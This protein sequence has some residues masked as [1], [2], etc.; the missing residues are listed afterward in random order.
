MNYGNEQHTYFQES[1]KNSL[2]LVSIL[3]QL[4]IEKR[5]SFRSLLYPFACIPSLVGTLSLWTGISSW[6]MMQIWYLTLIFVV[7]HMSLFLYGMHL[8]G[9]YNLISIFLWEKISQ[10]YFYKFNSLFPNKFSLHKSSKRRIIYYTKSWLITNRNSYHQPNTNKNYCSTIYFSWQL[11]KEK[12]AKIKISREI[13][14]K[15]KL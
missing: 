11:N 10:Q 15:Y 1:E 5:K 3:G 4:K 13:F 8:L 9:D 12:K 2:I 14:N 7:L 6:W